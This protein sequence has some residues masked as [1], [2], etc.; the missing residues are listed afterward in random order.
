M[1]IFFLQLAIIF[2]PGLVWE[3]IDAQFAQK[4]V[5]TQ[6][7]VLRRTFVFGVVAYIVTYGICRFL[8][9]PFELFEPKKD[10]T[11]LGET[12][13]R[14][15]FIATFV[16]FS[17]SIVWL[18]FVNFKI[19]MRFMKRIRATKRYG[20]EDVWDFTF[21]AHDRNVEYVHLRDFDK[22]IVY[23]GWVERFS[24]TEKVRELVLHDV[25]VYDFEGNELFATPRARWTILTSNFR[26]NP[27]EAKIGQESRRLHNAGTRTRGAQC[28]HLAGYNAPADACSDKLETGKSASAP[29]RQNKIGGRRL[30]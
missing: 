25:K 16:A 10:S 24:D 12:A 7:D 19:L 27:R 11:F 15:I 5:P 18:Y 9:F 30:S 29:N 13:V 1:D 26:L 3:R 21:N 6:F 28:A 8:G 17:C 23:A 2:L 22:E 14:E 20:D 4:R